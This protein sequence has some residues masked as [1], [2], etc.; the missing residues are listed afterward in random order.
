MDI[1]TP[2]KKFE[3]RSERY[4]KF[5]YAKIIAIVNQDG[6]VM[7]YDYTLTQNANDFFA[8]P[9]DRKKYKAITLRPVACE[10]MSELQEKFRIALTYLRLGAALTTSDAKETMKRL[11][12]HCGSADWQNAVND[13]GMM[14][15]L[16][17]YEEATFDLEFTWVRNKRVEFV[18]VSPL[19][20]GMSVYLTYDPCES[21]SSLR[22]VNEELKEAD[23]KLGDRIQLCV[24]PPQEDP[25]E[26]DM[27]KEMWVTVVAC[28]REMWMNDDEDDE[29]DYFVQDVIIGREDGGNE[30]IQFTPKHVIQ[31]TRCPKPSMKKI[32]EQQSDAS[33]PV[34]VPT[35]VPSVSAVLAVAKQACFAVEALR[36]D[37]VLLPA[38]T[39]LRQRRYHPV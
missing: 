33:P 20:R 13:C 35:P 29:D 22:V 28:H 21:S 34:M 9:E 3:R 39:L 23:Y 24:D 38:P 32:S 19:A 10:N 15:P 17:I 5:E 12:E 11:K 1:E 14:I 36:E 27:P 4:N 16:G 37:N 7:D 6:E 18:H 25:D 26:G 8:D 31:Y 2:Y 30:L